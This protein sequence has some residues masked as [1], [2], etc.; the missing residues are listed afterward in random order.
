MKNKIK[1]KYNT[2]NHYKFIFNAVMIIHS[3]ITIM[4]MKSNI[5]GQVHILLDL[6]MVVE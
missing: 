6:K 4:G 5:L 1:H 2:N 3:S